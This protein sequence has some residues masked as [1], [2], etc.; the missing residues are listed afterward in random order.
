MKGIAMSHATTT[1]SRHADRDPPSNPRRMR[2][3][4]WKPLARNT[5]LGFATIQ[6]ASGLVL[7]D[8]T[9]HRKGERCWASPPG[10]PKLDQSGTALRDRETGKIEYAQ[11]VSFEPDALR[12]RWSDAVV[13]T[14]RRDFPEAF[15]PPPQ[16]APAPAAPPRPRDDDL[17]DPIPF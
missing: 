3:I 2:C 17:N 11:L 6:H 14:V 10:K 7:S 12:H 4:A 16:A 15:E 8:I 13:D 9:V 5:L 1:T